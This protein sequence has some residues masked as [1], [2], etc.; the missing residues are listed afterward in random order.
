MIMSLKLLKW[1]NLIAALVTILINA[2][3]EIIPINNIGTG[4]ISDSIPNLFVPAGL[5]FSIWGIIYILFVVFA[6]VQLRG[7]EIDA[8]VEKIGYWFIISSI[9]NC[10]WIFLWHYILI[11]E[12]VIV[13]I[14]LLISL[15]IIY[16][17][18]QIGLSD[19][20]K[21]VRYGIH[22]M[23]SVYLGWITVATIADITAVLVKVGWN[24]WGIADNVW[25]DVVIIVAILITS[26]MLLLRKDLGYAAV[27]E[28]AFLGIVLKRTA[29]SPPH[30]DI[31][32][33]TIVGMILIAVLAML[34]ILRK[35]K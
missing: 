2:L 21:Q 10:A 3:A 32:V 24:G 22:L 16:L 7:G 35:S 1:L 5:T 8:V 13:M 20:S 18:L 31:V 9:A 4:T 26:L 17:K 33:I 23:V 19:V 27:V 12:T 25:T 30:L 6:I 34:K 29:I 15:L 11:W 28:W 14:V